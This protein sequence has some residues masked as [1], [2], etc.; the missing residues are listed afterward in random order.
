MKST[1]I[2]KAFN[3]IQDDFIE[4]AAPKNLLPKKTSF[5]WFNMKTLAGAFAVILIAIFMGNITRKPDVAVVNPYVSCSSFAEASE[6][7]G[8]TLSVP[9]TF[10]ESDMMEISVISGTM[11]EGKYLENEKTILT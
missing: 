6:I 8:Y 1:D 5:A 10:M 7:T 2:I 3:D 9:D 4:E 11:T